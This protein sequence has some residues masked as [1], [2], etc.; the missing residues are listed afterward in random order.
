MKKVFVPQIQKKN[1]ARG[2]AKMILFRRLIP[3]ET[4]VGCGELNERTLCLSR[5]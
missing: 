2:N 5:N 4:G 3:G 1:P